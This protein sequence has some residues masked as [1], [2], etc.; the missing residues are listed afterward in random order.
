MYCYI[1]QYYIAHARSFNTVRSTDIINTLI[2]DN[3]LKHTLLMSI[4]CD[5]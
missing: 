2:V 5:Y 4:E 3:A 1:M